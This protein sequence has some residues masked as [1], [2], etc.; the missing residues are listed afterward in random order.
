[1]LSNLEFQVQLQKRFEVTSHDLCSLSSLLEITEYEYMTL[2]DMSEDFE[3]LLP[4]VYYTFLTRLPMMMES[5]SSRL[6][7]RRC[8]ASTSPFILMLHDMFSIKLFP[9][10]LHD[11]DDRSKFLLLHDIHVV[12]RIDQQLDETYSFSQPVAA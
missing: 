12:R 9:T 4:V 10:D 2:L 5:L 7:Y 11:G 8:L 6:L 3:M 1:M